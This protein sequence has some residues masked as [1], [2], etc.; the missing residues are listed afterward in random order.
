MGLISVLCNLMLGYMTGKLKSR[1]FLA[2]LPLVVAIAFT[3]IADIDTPRR[4]LIHIVPQNLQ[5]L[6]AT[7]R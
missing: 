1:A 4:G 6:E 7:L 2:I 3:L 5:A